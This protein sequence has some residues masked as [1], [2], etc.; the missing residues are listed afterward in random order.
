MEIKQKKN[1][2]HTAE[3]QTN[4]IKQKEIIWREIKQKEVTIFDI[5]QMDIK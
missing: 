1:V 2:Y 4:W 3:E 5:K